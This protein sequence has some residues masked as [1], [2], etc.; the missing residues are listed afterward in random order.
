MK[1]AALIVLA[2]CIE[3]PPVP[4]QECTS[5]SDCNAGE[6]CDEGVC[7]GNPPVGS[8]A[9]TISPPAV[10]EDLVSSEIP[11]L[12]LPSDGW[13]G[14]I[15]LE[16]PVT[17]SGRI[18]AACTA[19]QTTCPSTSIGAEVRFTRPSRF[20]G[21]P[22]VRLSAQSKPGLPRGTDSFT[23]RVPRTLP[24]DAPY[25]VTI[26][27]DG[28]A[29]LPP[30]HGGKD[31]AELVP[32]RRLIMFATDD[33]EHQTY[34]VGSTAP[35]TISGVLK[36]PLGSYLTKYRVVAR[37]RW[38]EQ[39]SPTEISTVCFSTDGTYSI[40]L[41]EG[42]LGPIE[43]VAKP[44]DDTTV[45]PELHVSNID[46]YGPQVRNVA[47][48][49][50]LGA[51]V[52]LAIKVEG[53][54][55]RD[56][57]V[58]P[59]S[60]A[61]VKII[62][63][64]ENNV[65]SG[66]TAVMADEGVTGDDGIARLSVLDGATLASAY[67]MHIVPPADSSFGVV[68]GATVQL[69][70]PPVVRLPQRIA[71][72]GTVVDVHGDPLPDVSI[73]ARRSLRFLW[74]LQSN[75]QSFLNE[76]P[77]ATA[78][79][80]DSGEFRVWVDPAVASAWGHYDLFFETPEGSR[81]PN[82]AIPDYEIPRDPTLT[83]ISLGTVTIPD[84]A[85]LHGKIVDGNGNLVEGSLMRVFQLSTNETVCR[86]VLNAPEECAGDAKA[87]GHGESDENGIVRFSLPRP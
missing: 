58:K 65:T 30:A 8:W 33:I 51:R 14:D 60:G 69:P 5:N 55:P 32:P 52:D 3:I 56:G 78:T 36:D 84:A 7:W 73:T 27:P 64:T 77:A 39:T 72:T 34:L 66:I 13:L 59:V 57:S 87:L 53:L 68:Y 61:R 81:A 2:G 50:G 85:Y 80:P 83:T 42:V 47:Q 28:G 23:I 62:G 70:S 31:P 48:P 79:T 24:G 6:V 45:A 75:E 82:W 41:A 71:I 35:Q 49:T 16:A 40:T 86:E 4:G 18:E 11:M 29:A 17:I 9:T 74:S 15:T 46:P 12:D 25:K 19:S 37:G 1:C 22:A 10:R 43:L 38:D 20:P 44:Y 21:G 26:D 76:I 67:R 54:D 63:S